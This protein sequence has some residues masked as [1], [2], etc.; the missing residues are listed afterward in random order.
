MSARSWQF[1]L[2][3]SASRTLPPAAALAVADWLAD[4]Y[5]CRAAT[6]R[7]VV[8]HNLELLG[9][10]PVS[11]ASPRIR[12]VF[13]NFG[14]YL[15][16][17]FTAH[18]PDRL[19]IAIE[20]HTHLRAA[21]GEGRGVIALTAHLGNWEAGAVAMRRLG[22][23][24]AAVALPHQDRSIN[25]LF[26]RQRERCGVDSIPLGPAAA[27]A[28]LDRLREGGLVGL[29]GDQVFSG[30]SLDVRF[31]QGRLR[32]P[33]GPAVLSLRAGAP[34]LPV[35]ILREGPGRLRMRL[36][37]AILPVAAVGPDRVA[38]LTQRYADVM[39][40]Y[41]AQYPEQWVMFQRLEAQGSDGP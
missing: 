25:E 24:I 16:E 1:R 3:A 17:F 31:S 6:D 32:V 9:G 8:R 4:A 21:Q 28:C 11:P 5:S 7:A 27:A 14:R 26:T 35:F 2:A 13:R 12:D 15:V 36:E 30:S 37:P 40:R 41:V 10:E 22:C 20:G 18:R 34:V 29:L 38:T 19:P 39:A 33:R 23:R